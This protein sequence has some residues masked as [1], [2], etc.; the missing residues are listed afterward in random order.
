MTS[1]ADRFI[2]AVPERTLCALWTANPVNGSST[3][4][5]REAYLRVG[6]FDP[7]LRNVD[8]DGDL[9]MRVLISGQCVRGIEGA[10]VFYRVHPGQTTQ[11]DARMRVGTEATRIRVI[12]GLA[13]GGRLPHILL[14][15]GLLY[16]GCT[17]SRGSVRFPAAMAELWDALG[18][19]LC[20]SQTVARLL[21]KERTFVE[22][23]ER[24][25]C[26]AAALADSPVWKDFA[27]RFGLV[28]RRRNTYER[29]H[30]AS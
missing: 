11:S 20:A 1:L 18:S 25:R 28:D 3:M 5:D 14:R 16:A 27:E 4:F 23:I 12:R 24:S 22:V 30:A 15:G 13:A 17:V 19:I 2:E 21:G 8:A 29:G 6:G 10:P 9:L 7:I 26:E